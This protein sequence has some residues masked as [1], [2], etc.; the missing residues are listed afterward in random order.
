MDM[1]DIVRLNVVI[2]T[3][4]HIYYVYFVLRSYSKCFCFVVSVVILDVQCPYFSED[5]VGDDSGLAGLILI[6]ESGLFFLM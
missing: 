5:E 4:P 1:W 3:V 6:Y 2:T